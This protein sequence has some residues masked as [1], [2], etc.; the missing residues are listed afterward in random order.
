MHGLV[1]HEDEP[2]KYKWVDSSMSI[3]FIL[4][5]NEILL[6]RNDIPYII[7]NKSF[8]LIIILYK[9]SAKSI[10]HPKDKNL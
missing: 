5:V 1:E 8:I 3:F 2:C 10:P 4:Y 7:R 6:I 9:G